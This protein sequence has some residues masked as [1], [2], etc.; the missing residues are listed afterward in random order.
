MVRI[1][2]PLQLERSSEVPVLGHLEC[3]HQGLVVP[4]HIAGVGRFRKPVLYPLSYEDV[5]SL[6]PTVAR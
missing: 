1:D 2:L 3:L 4:W 6:S 5:G